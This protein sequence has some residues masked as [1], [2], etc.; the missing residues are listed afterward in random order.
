MPAF[1]R[2]DT[3]RHLVEVRARRSIARINGVAAMRFTMEPQVLDSQNQ[4]D[5]ERVATK[6][7]GM[8]GRIVPDAAL[9][10][11]INT[12]G[13]AAGDRGEAQAVIRARSPKGF[14]FVASVEAGVA[15]PREAAK[16]PRSILAA[17]KR[18]AAEARA[19]AA[20]SRYLNLCRTQPAR[21]LKRGLVLLM[22]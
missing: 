10:T 22:T 2:V 16:S 11:R 3:N 18:R 7:R 4:R 14:R 9:T 6:G 12:A 8:R 1:W 21:A 13:R 5:R 20:R 15:V 17:H 19:P